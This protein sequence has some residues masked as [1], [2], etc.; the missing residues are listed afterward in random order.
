MSKINV[1]VSLDITDQKTIR[2]F[3]DFLYAVADSES[4]GEPKSDEPESDEP[5]P[6]PTSAAPKSPA[7]SRAKKET[8]TTEPAVS[9]SKTEETP[10]KDQA[11][12]NEQTKE[13]DQAGSKEA[14]AVAS[15]SL[16]DIR[17]NMSKKVTDHR[18]ALQK[19]LK[20]F[21]AKN[22]TTLPVDKYDEFNQYILDL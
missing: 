11:V 15:V 13:E 1:E 5:A 2:A 21:G 7:R 22:I 17:S 10:E 8:P 3:A 6:A 18:E 4:K 19:K 20:E 9:E 14:D 12:S 16:D